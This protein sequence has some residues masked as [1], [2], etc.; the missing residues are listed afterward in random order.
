MSQN[1]GVLLSDAFHAVDIGFPE[2]SSNTVQ[3]RV[4]FVLCIY[5]PA[6]AF[7]LM[8]A[9]VAGPAF[10]QYIRT[11]ARPVDTTIFALG[12]KSMS[13]GA[14]TEHWF[15]GFQVFR[16]RLDLLVREVTEA[17]AD[18][19]QISRVDCLHPGD[20]LLILR[21]DEAVVRIDREQ[22]CGF[23]AVALGKNLRQHRAAFFGPVF[24]ITCD[25]DDVF[26]G[27]GT[28]AAFEDECI[29]VQGERQHQR[30]Q[31]KK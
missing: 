30:S 25:Q 24:F 27:T 9:V 16:E 7:H 14:E 26:T 1:C 22:H 23:E 20:V 31:E 10:P 28:F 5:H 2:E 13:R 18:K 8:S 21:I 15:A 6:S 4:I 12:F 17:G 19:N 29:G 3:N 11:K